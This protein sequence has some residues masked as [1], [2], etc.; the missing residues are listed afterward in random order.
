MDFEIEMK[1]KRNVVKCV[2]VKPVLNSKVG[3]VRKKGGFR[4]KE[5]KLKERKPD[6]SLACSLHKRKIEEMLTPLKLQGKEEEGSWSGFRR[7]GTA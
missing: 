7:E 1:G 3:F 2:V 5:R 6:E 4:S